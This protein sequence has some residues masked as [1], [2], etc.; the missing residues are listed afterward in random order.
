MSTNDSKMIISINRKHTFLTEG[1]IKLFLGEAVWDFNEDRVEHFLGPIFLCF[2]KFTINPK[3][4]KTN[5]ETAVLF[6]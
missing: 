5:G 3:K 1:A 6:V 4:K 2:H